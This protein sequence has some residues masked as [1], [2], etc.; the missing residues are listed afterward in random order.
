ML[1]K[2]FFAIIFCATIFLNFQTAFAEDLVFIDAM[3]DT[4][5]YFDMDS[6]KRESSDVFFVDF[7]VIRANKNEMAI[8]NLKINHRKKNY[9]VRSTKTLSYDERTE[10]KTE[11]GNNIVRSYSEKS[12][13]YEAVKMI[14]EQI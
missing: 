12:V 11:P 10:L 3:G 2:N 4:G 7:I 14:L 6:V 1:K 13:M 8:A 9:F 5:Y